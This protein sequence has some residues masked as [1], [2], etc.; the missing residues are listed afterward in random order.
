MSESNVEKVNPVTKVKLGDKEVTLKFDLW[1]LLKLEEA[2]GVNALDGKVWL[3]PRAK[4]VVALLWAAM[5]HEQPSLTMEEVAKSIALEDIGSL[6]ESL[7]AT[8]EKASS[9]EDLTKKNE[10][11]ENP[12]QA[13]APIG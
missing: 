7:G 13:A 1:A 3:N 5:L 10:G 12:E 6:V 9:P 8:F 4:D 11:A 2:T